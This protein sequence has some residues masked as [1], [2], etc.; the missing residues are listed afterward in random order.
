MIGQWGFGWGQWPHK[1]TGHSSH[2]FRAGNRG[3]SLTERRDRRETARRTDRRQA[4]NQD[5]LMSLVLTRVDGCECIRDREFSFPSQVLIVGSRKS[6]RTCRCARLLGQFF[7]V[8]RKKATGSPCG[9][10]NRTPKFFEPHPIPPFLLSLGTL[11]SVQSQPL[12]SPKTG[13]ARN[14]VPSRPSR[15]RAKQEIWAVGRTCPSEVCR[16]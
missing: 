2:A 9:S 3:A 1:S 16:K 13:R 6:P 11:G 10:A 15:P 8:G 14:H 4:G 7:C 5:A 12:P